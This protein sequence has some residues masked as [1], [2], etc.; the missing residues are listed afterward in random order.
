MNYSCLYLSRYGRIN[1]V[2]KLQ[3]FVTERVKGD[4]REFASRTRKPRIRVNDNK[5]LP[6]LISAVILLATSGQWLL[7][8][9]LYMPMASVHLESIETGV[10]RTLSERTDDNGNRL[11]RVWARSATELQR[12]L[13]RL[14]HT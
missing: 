6:V 10:A 7:R 8:H 3:R 12:W 11:D 14:V 5:R 4:R 2:V 1:F 13:W 9:L